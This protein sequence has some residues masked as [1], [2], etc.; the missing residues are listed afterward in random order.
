MGKF[1]VV[2]VVLTLVHFS[3]DVIWFIIG[4]Y[5][6]I[7]FIAVALGIILFSSAMGYVIRQPKIK[8]FLGK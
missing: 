8:A 2:T 6:E 4:R 5:T 7:S 1:I 3:E